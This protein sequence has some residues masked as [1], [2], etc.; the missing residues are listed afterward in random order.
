MIGNH[1]ISKVYDFPLHGWELLRFFFL[2][3]IPMPFSLGRCML[4]YVSWLSSSG[5]PFFPVDFF[6]TDTADAA[7]AN[8]TLNNVTNPTFESMLWKC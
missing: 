3:A 1:I 8:I 6:D 7:L 5:I 2:L 4:F